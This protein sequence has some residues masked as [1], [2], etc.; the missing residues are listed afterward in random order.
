MYN[1]TEL[2]NV[3][4]NKAKEDG[5]ADANV[6]YEYMKITLDKGDMTKAKNI[7]DEAMKLNLTI[8]TDSQQFMFLRQIMSDYINQNGRFGNFEEK[9]R[10]IQLAKTKFPNDIIIKNWF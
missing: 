4:F 8:N 3:T 5:L 7:F 2:A 9:E 1:Q 6:F 10:C